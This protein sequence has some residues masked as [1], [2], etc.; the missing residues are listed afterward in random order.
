MD[1]GSRSQGLPVRIK[2]HADI[3]RIKKIAIGDWV[4]LRAAEDVKLKQGDM[5]YIS[6]GISVQLPKGYEAYIAP[7]SST[8]KQF[9]ILC[10]NSI[11]IID[12]SYCGEN[13]IW[14]FCAYAIRDTEIHKGDRICQFRV[15]RNQEPLFLYEVTEMK[16]ED[17][18]G[19]GS[20][21]R[22]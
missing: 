10:G 17:R 22:A 1:E 3:P 8:L 2:Y 21:G 11:G 6:L 13:D 4:D 7:R 12:N 14:H 19:I 9:G 18:G 15:M 16:N 20:T 5:S